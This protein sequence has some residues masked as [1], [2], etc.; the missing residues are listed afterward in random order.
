MDDMQI[1]EVTRQEEFDTQLSGSVVRVIF[2][3]KQNYEASMDFTWLDRSYTF[4]VTAWRSAGMDK[5]IKL[6]HQYCARHADEAPDSECYN[7]DRDKFLP[8]GVDFHQDT[9][10]VFMPE[11]PDLY[12]SCFRSMSNNRKG[13]KH[14]HGLHFSLYP[15]QRMEIK[16][17]NAKV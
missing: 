8:D 9:M 16:A 6:F 10:L 5:F 17:L 13:K 2:S 7:V 1:H 11:L 12:P 4:N 3:M 15:T 14:V